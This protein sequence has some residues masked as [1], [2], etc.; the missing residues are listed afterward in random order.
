MRKVK[1]GVVGGGGAFYFHANGIRNSEILEYTAIYDVNYENAKRMARKYQNNPM[2][3]YETLDEMLDSDID[4]VLVMVPHVFHDDIVVRCA[5]KKKHVL[6][7]K[8]MG[9]TLEGC[10]RMIDACREN[11]V[12][13]MIAENH[14]FLPAHNCVH[15]LIASG[16]IG[17]VLMIRAY[18]GVN[19][20][21][22]LSQS[23]FWKGDPIKAGGGSL[24]DMAA[25]KFATIEYIM[26]SRCEEVTSV[27]AKQMINLPEKAEDNAVAI[28]RYENGAI[29]DVMVSFTQMIP[30][31]NSL[32]VY[33]TEGTIFENH[34]WE[35]P[36]RV[37]S[38]TSKDERMRQKWYE[39]ECEHAPFPKY[40]PISVKRED[41]YF[42]TC[43]LENKEPEF[44]PEQA[45]H[46]IE[47]ILTGYLSHI[48]KRP[49]RCEEVRKM[50]EE[51][52]T[53]EILEKLAASIPINKNL[54]EIKMR[55]PIG[56]R[57]EKAAKLMEKY[58]LDLLIATSAMHTYYV[59]GLPVLHSAPN[60]ILASL[61]N[62]Y[63]YMG[64]VRRRGENTVFHWNVYKSVDDLCWAADSVGIESPL[65]VQRALKWK[66]KQWGMEGKRVGVE[67][68]A[69]KYVMEVLEDPE[70][71]L[72]IVT[73]DQVFRD[74]RLVK[75]DEEMACILKATEITETALRAC[76]DACAVG[77]TDNELLAIG[78][79]A[80]LEAGASDWDHTTMTI[81]DSDPEAPGTGRAIKE[82]EIIRLDFG[83]TYKGYVAD[84]NCHVIVGKTPEEAKEV[85]DA[86]L[87]YQG[88]IE[89]RV[90]PGQNMKKLGEEARAYYQN[91][92]PRSLAS[93]IG[94]SIG[95]ECEDV[96]IL[97]YLGAI[98]GPFEENMVFE[99]EAWENYAGALIGVEDTYV[100]TKDGCKK[101]TTIPKYIIEKEVK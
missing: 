56:Y 11:G 66:L 27:L 80:M 41:E 32:E 86:L 8:P 50:G 26:G 4:A 15:D 62:Q 49:V 69:P 6:C 55:E 101:V 68:T 84:V 96:H 13:F 24:M 77:V 34:A 48:E 93:S 92:Y 14:R 16:A 91:K 44:T 58:N 9:T 47:A 17:R 54:K 28:A 43:V 31:F 59:T 74:M 10:Q 52:R 3:A 64:L 71:N 95:L 2:T 57:K 98:D 78:K 22:G 76:I 29:A 72:E 7:E 65:D 38:M 20:I 88:Y 73:A 75:T 61:A 90:K 67:S 30:P 70:Y 83:A 87:D 81:G 5:Q 89:A 45:M 100:V 79:K 18:E 25:H 94:H 36:V 51:G 46:A 99:I 53:H 23:G 21:P 82:G 42:A 1:F 40:Y 19:E 33:G 12:L 97:G 63:P 37:Y 85:I 39:P 60:P 35:K